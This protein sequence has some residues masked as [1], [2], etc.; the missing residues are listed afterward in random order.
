MRRIDIEASKDEAVN[1]KLE[2]SLSAS[3]K[4]CFAKEVDRRTLGRMSRLE[5]GSSG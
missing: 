3:S 2:G 5:D 1:E 4:R